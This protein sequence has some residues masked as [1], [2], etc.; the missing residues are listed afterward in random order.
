M[1]QGKQGQQLE[2][3]GVQKGEEDGQGGG[4]DAGQ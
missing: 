1:L 2:R 3:G 4:E